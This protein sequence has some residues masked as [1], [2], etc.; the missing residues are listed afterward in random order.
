[1]SLAPALVIVCN[2]VEEEI[3]LARP[4]ACS[5]FICDDHKTILVAS[6]QKELKLLLYT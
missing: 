5:H 6:Y 2:Y 3:R 1:M 4:S